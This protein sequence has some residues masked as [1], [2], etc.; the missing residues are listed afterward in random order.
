MSAPI[1]TRRIAV[2][3]SVGAISLFAVSACSQ[4]D[5]SA[6][7]AAAPFGPCGNSFEELRLAAEVEGKLT[8]LGAP[9]EWA[10]N[11]AIIDGFADAYGIT[12]SSIY[13]DAPSGEELT[14]MRT[15]ENHPRRPDVAD[16]APAVAS[17]ATDEGLVTPYKSTV[18]ESIPA[19]F[20]STDGAWQASYLG[21]M[22]FGVD[23]GQVENVPQTWSD[24]RKPEYR[25]MVTLNGDPRDSGV[26]TAA[27]VGASLANGGSLDDVM[28]GIEFF[29][30]LKSLGNLNS[31][32]YTR[33]NLLYGD[34]PLALD[35][36]YALQDSLSA[37]VDKGMDFEVVQ[38]DD[39]RVAI[40]YAQVIYANAS[41]PCAA[42]LWIE[43]VNSDEAARLRNEV[44]AISTR[45]ATLPSSGT[46]GSTGR[47]ILD[48][49]IDGSVAVP[50]P[51]QL[52]KI[53]NDIDENWGPMVILVPEDAQ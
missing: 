7:L 24:L 27:V 43:Y 31:T 12:V 20:K 33:A 46:L 47:R 18:W 9:R 49:L 32:A 13:P 48:G 25:G 14:L 39:G 38:P 26:A 50:N 44:D 42:R 1:R 11:G 21:E 16:L 37:I 4:S 6:A 10:N 28:P 53:Q 17:Q 30:D 8:L 15:W 3:V 52:V 5:P 45:Y 34:V 19:E 41:H 23:L 35:W 36:N 2:W 29:S 51:A 40:S 22:S